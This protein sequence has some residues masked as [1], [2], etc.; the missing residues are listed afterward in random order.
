M[1]LGLKIPVDFERGKGLWAV[2]RVGGGWPE[3]D[4]PR[5]AAELG[6]WRSLQAWL[7]RERGCPP[8]SLG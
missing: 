8:L 4:G 1:I 6:A 2:L 3:K 7:G 5:E